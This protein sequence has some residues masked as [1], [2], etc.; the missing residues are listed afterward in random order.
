MK[1]LKSAVQIQ[2][3]YNTKLSELYMTAYLHISEKKTITVEKLKRSYLHVL[4]RPS[5]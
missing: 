5:H 3:I 1:C 2:E 4:Y